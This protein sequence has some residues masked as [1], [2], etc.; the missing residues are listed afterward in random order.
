MA[1]PQS[2]VLAARRL[3]DRFDDWRDHAVDRK[4]G[5]DTRCAPKPAAAPI[6]LAAGHGYYY[7]PIQLA[8]FRRIMKALPVEPAALT[9][10]DFGSGKG[11]ALI[12]AAEQ[13]FR[14]V[15]GIEYAQDL[16]AASQS[17]VARYRAAANDANPIELHCGDAARYDLPR[18]D[19]LCFFYNP[20]DET[21]MTL[22]LAR[23][24]HSLR[25][26]PRR[27]F[28]AYR[29]PRHGHLMSNAGFLRCLTRNSSFDLYEGV[30]A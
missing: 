5:I 12:F 3:I 15:I 14:R 21:A 11:R 23:M 10:I 1:L 30:T 2:A 9:F 29:N 7:E 22:A 20:F 26:R 6:A 16:F 4:Y 18:E 19:C 28:I 25:Q 27:L 17:N 13:R 8:V 24:R